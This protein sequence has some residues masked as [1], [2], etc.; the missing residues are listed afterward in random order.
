M[1]G[2]SREPRFRPYVIASSFP[3]RLINRAGNAR[4]SLTSRSVPCNNGLNCL[5]PVSRAAGERDCVETRTP[6]IITKHQHKDKSHC[7]SSWP[8]SAQPAVR[9]TNAKPSFRAASAR[10]SSSVTTW[11][12]AGRCSAAMKAAASC[13]A[14]AARSGCTRRNR[15]ALSRTTSLGSISC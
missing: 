10:R 9:S 4:G 8:Q 11:S 7:R 1:S 6:P 13:N 3:I 5:G 2:N 14:S 12:D 15:I